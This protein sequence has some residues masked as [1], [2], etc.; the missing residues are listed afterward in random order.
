M[1]HCNP[2]CYIFVKD[3]IRKRVGKGENILKTH[4]RKQQFN[5]TLISNK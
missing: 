1:P 3:D 5:G 4:C 2:F